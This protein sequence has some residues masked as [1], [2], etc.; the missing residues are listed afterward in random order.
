M[1]WS[2]PYT[3]PEQQVLH[4]DAS[5]KALQTGANLEKVFLQSLVYGPYVPYSLG[6]GEIQFSPHRVVLTIPNLGC[7]PIQFSPLNK[8]IE[9]FRTLSVLYPEGFVQQDVWE[10]KRRAEADVPEDQIFVK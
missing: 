7:S 2:N 8:R 5:R 1:V 3:A 10:I 6:R 4:T 9:F